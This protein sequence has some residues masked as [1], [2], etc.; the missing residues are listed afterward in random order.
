M[1][2]QGSYG[3]KGALLGEQACIK[4]QEIGSPPRHYGSHGRIITESTL[5]CVMGHASAD[6]IKRRGDKL[7]KKSLKKT[8]DVFF[9][10]PSAPS[11]RLAA[12]FS[13]MVHHKQ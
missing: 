8:Y 2:H 5:V 11:A 12:I 10:L 13:V 4:L 9:L 1:A 3:K 6:V 7:T